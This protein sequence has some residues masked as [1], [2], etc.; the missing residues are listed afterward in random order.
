MSAPED[1]ATVLAEIR[2]VAAEIVEIK[3]DVKRATSHLADVDLLRA[4]VESIKAHLKKIDL[5]MAGPPALQER[6]ERLEA[7]QESDDQAR[8]DEDATT[9]AGAGVA[10]DLAHRE[11]ASEEA[12]V[13][14]TAAERRQETVNV[15]F[16]EE[17]NR[18]ERALFD[19]QHASL[20]VQGS[21]IIAGV[22]VI[23]LLTR[24]LG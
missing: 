7:K 2:A 23:Y 11:M 21:I 18:F 4:D 5:L 17:L 15:K 12:G 20:K 24:A 9:R 1:I 8:Q 13:L 3:A 19:F 22:A 16:R 10:G 6:L 14:V